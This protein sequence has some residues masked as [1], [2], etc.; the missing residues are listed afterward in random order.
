MADIK[1]I[2]YGPGGHKSEHDSASDSVQFASYK[3]AS[4]ELTDAN[5]TTLLQGNDATA[6][7][8]HDSRYYTQASFADAFASNVVTP[9]KTQADG[10]IDE[11][12]ID[13]TALEDLLAHDNF[14]DAAA[15]RIHEEYIFEDGTRD[16]S[17]DQ[18]MG[19]NLLTNV[20]SSAASIT[21]PLHAA[22]KAYVDAVAL[23]LRPKGDVRVATTAAGVLASD[24]EAGD[25]ID[26]VV[27]VA[28]DR[29]LIKDQADAKE[30]GIYVVEASGAP[31]RS[32]DQDNAPLAEILNGVFVP[33]VLEGTANNGR[34]YLISSE[35]TGADRLHII[36]TDDI[37]FTE[38]SSPSQLNAGLGI[39]AALFATNVVA[40]D[41]VLNGGLA[42]NGQ[43]IEV[44]VADFVGDGLVDNAGDID[45]DWAT[46]FTIDAADAKAFKASDL[47][48]TATGAGASIV[49]VED[50]NGYFTGDNQ[51]AVNNEL[52]LIA[53]A[54]DEE[55]YTVGA[56]GVSAGDLVYLDSNDTVLPLSNIS[57]D[58]YVVGMA[59]T[60]E[61][62]AAE[63]AV[64]RFDSVLAGVLT[65]ATAGDIYYWDGSALTTTRPS[66]GNNNV[67]MAGIAKNATDLSVEVRHLFKKI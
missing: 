11:G 25:T 62:A 31:T 38:F 20:G 30:N 54:H 60:T 34:A 64:S 14:S 24:F 32:E 61:S 41:L 19:G 45:I 16:F 29:I 17:G 22:N 53:S 43:E 40:V 57:D 10:Y 55:K 39:D 26:G 46:D 13:I 35:G 1:V 48:S 12:F 33:S 27:L 58:D 56:G 65:G 6:L 2:K 7:H 49:G 42:F 4:N 21:D 15:S 36:G 50:A 23:G 44:V 66:G 52:Y 47:A 59:L 9:V 18:S 37:E 63:V 3:T 8:H 67:W 51:E 5:L 28:G